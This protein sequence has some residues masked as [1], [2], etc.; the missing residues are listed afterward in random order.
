MPVMK[1]SWKRLSSKIV[2]K[3]PWYD[4]RQDRVITPLGKKGIYNVIVVPSAVAIVALNENEEVALIELYRYTTQMSSIEVPAGGSEGQ[5]PLSAA[6]RELREE[7]GLV[8]KK[9]KKLGRVQ[10]A[11]GHLEQMAEIFLA[12]ELSSTQ[13]H[14][15]QEDGI[16]KSYFVPLEKAMSMI[17]KGQ[18]TDCL[19]ITALCMA[20]ME[21]QKPKR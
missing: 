13:D 9:W 20:A 2:H 3:N 4:V 11:N 16:Q 19:S 6:K 8:A 17:Q 10:A 12:T 15:Q 14:Q 18:V 7:T 21:L 1:N 5:S